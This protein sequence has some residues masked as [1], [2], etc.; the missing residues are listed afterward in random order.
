MNP[1]STIL[2]ASVLTVDKLKSCQEKNSTLKNFP[3]Q[4]T[5]LEDIHIIT[6]G[7]IIITLIDNILYRLSRPR[8]KNQPDKILKQIIIPL[9][10]RRA[11]FEEIHDGTLG[12][13]MGYEKTYS[14]IYSILLERN[15][16][17]CEEM[18]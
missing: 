10:L 1:D 12:A 6:P 2:V 8:L 4:L 17:R 16:W 7:N 5:K 13:H 15:V 11:V 3:D 14:K 18:Y 9:D